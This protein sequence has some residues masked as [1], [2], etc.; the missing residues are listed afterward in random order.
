M[1]SGCE[2]DQFWGRGGPALGNEDPNSSYQS[3]M[4]WE[5]EDAPS[6]LGHGVDKGPEATDIG[7]ITPLPDEG[8]PDPYSVTPNQAKFFSSDPRSWTPRVTGLTY[9]LPFDDSHYGCSRGII[10]EFMRVNSQ[11]LAVGEPIATECVRLTDTLIGVQIPGT[12]VPGE[13]YKVRFFNQRTW[14]WGYLGSELIIRANE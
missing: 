14:Y 1:R 5:T 13:N 9:P 12:L 7:T 2:D 3:F 4:C 8:Q 10:A 6:S 11:D